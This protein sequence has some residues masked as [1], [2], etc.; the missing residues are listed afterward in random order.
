MFFFCVFYLVDV[1]A[2]VVG[3]EMNVTCLCS[4]LTYRKNILMFKFQS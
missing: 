2:K 3:Y 1:R 4:F